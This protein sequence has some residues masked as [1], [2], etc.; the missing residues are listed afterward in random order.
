M[1][2]TE[3]LAEYFDTDDFAVAAV[4]TLSGGGTETANVILDV[5]TEDLFA[6]RVLFDDYEITFRATDLP[7][8]A[9]GLAIAVDGANYTVREVRK[10]DDGKLK[11]A[12]LAKA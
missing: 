3:N 5:P 9:G 2:A 4:L 10:I 11:R 7:G 6:G 12:K 8:I 1:A